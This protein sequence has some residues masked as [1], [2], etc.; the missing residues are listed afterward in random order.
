MSGLRET[1]RR[2]GGL[3]LTSRVVGGLWV[4]GQRTVP[5]P[6]NAAATAA[7]MAAFPT[8]WPTIRDYG[9]A[10]E[11][12][13]PFINEDPMLVCSLIPSLGKERKI[14]FASGDSCATSLIVNDKTI[15]IA[16][17]L[18]DSSAVN[19]FG[20]TI[21]GYNDRLDWQ[22]FYLSGTMYWDLGG[23]RMTRSISVNARHTLEL[24]NYYSILDG[25][26][27]SGSTVSAS[28]IGEIPMKVWS[29]VTVFG[30]FD[31]YDGIKWHTFA[32]CTHSG[33]AGLL[34][35]TDVIFSAAEG[36]PT[37]SETPAS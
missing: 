4:V 16:T 9:F 35:I 36:T 10:H 33:K 25:I 23:S 37:I 8:Q 11:A 21:P 2:R 5:S 3:E 24:G 28:V 31:V 30:T 15:L 20:G 6:Y 32:P 17:F 19:I 13:V 22:C 7:L 34:D 27:N 26:R 29:G 1:I 18:I 14:V 12:L